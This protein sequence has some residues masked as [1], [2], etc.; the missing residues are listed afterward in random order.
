MKCIRISPGDYE[1]DIIEKYNTI[2]RDLGCVIVDVIK[3]DVPEDVFQVDYDIYEPG[4][5]VPKELLSKI[6]NPIGENQ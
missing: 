4:E 5:E 1:F 3:E 2:L 6:V